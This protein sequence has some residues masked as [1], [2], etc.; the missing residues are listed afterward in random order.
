MLKPQ[1]LALSDSRADFMPE[2]V[3]FNPERVDFRLERAWGDERTIKQ[4][5]ERTEV[6]CVLEDFIPFGAAAQKSKGVQWTDK[7]MYR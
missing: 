1:T 5:D 3:D 4:T 7:W 6:P 2:R